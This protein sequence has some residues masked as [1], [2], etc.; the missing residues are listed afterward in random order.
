MTEWIVSSAVLILVVIVLRLIFRGRISLRLQYALWGIVLL[1]LL[2]PVS[3]GSSS[4][5]AA[6]IPGT[7]AKQPVIQPVIQA[8]QQP[9]VDYEEAYHQ[10]VERHEALGTDVSQ[11]PESELE[12]LRQEAQAIVESRSF[13]SILW[14][15]LPTIWIVGAAIM[16]VLLC[17]VNIRFY[18]SLYKHRRPLAVPGSKLRV[19]VADNTDTPCL[20]G[21]VKP[22]VYV[23]EAVSEDAVLL[24]HSIAHETTH[25]CHGDHIWSLLRGVCL[26]V[27]WYNPLVWWAAFLSQADAELACDE[28]TIRRLGEEERAEYGRT[29]IGMTCRKQTNVLSTATTMHTGKRGIKERILL[30]AKKPKTVIIALIAVVLIAAVAVVCT[31]TGAASGDSAPGESGDREAMEGTVQ[32][33]TIFPDGQVTDITIHYQNRTDIPVGKQEMRKILAWARGFSY[34]MPMEEEPAENNGSITLHYAD[35]TSV[36][37][38]IDVQEVN[39]VR[40]QVMHS[41][42]PVNW[43]RLV[44]L[45]EPEPIVPP[46]LPPDVTQPTWP[47][48]PP[49][50]PEQGGDREPEYIPPAE[51]VP[52]TPINVPV[53]Q[54]DVP[55]IGTLYERADP[56]RI[57]IAVQPTGVARSGDHIFYI[58]PEDQ[59]AFF[60]A[61]K[62]AV[63][64]YSSQ[65]RDLSEPAGWAVHYNNTRLYAYTDGTLS[66]FYGTYTDPE[67]TKDLYDL[68]VQAIRAKGIGE[69][70]YPSD[71]VGI[72]SVTMELYGTHT[73]WDGEKLRTL[74]SWLV[75]AE[76]LYGGAGCPFT[77]PLTIQLNNGETKTIMIAGDSCCAFM[78]N[79]VYYQYLHEDNRVFFELFDL[80]QLLHGAVEQGGESIVNMSWRWALDWDLYGDTYG[81]WA[82]TEAMKMVLQW[83][84]EE[85][86]YYRIE[87][88]IDIFW[89]AEDYQTE[90]A[91]MLKYLYETHSLE[92]SK[93]ALQWMSD[94]QSI[95]IFKLLAEQLDMDASTL[96][97]RM[98]V[99][100]E[101]ADSEK[102]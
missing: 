37:A 16:A 39:G 54:I 95:R 6:N 98:E 72:R 59:E 33:T 21:F 19:Y 79:G 2:L 11:L 17:F 51:T 86:D 3:F 31:F 82:V 75:N 48:T 46:T 84:E 26:A 94:E 8:V 91:Q 90:F 57:C 41:E 81:R 61:Y 60:A 53:A 9:A 15:S 18:A 78:S 30:I 27:H 29:L 65:N 49:T 10:V 69:P 34:G 43:Y 47:D 1:R 38:G 67:N 58:I 50:T 24:R 70:V 64:E 14:D 80:M 93:T 66:T 12:V 25:F 56:D 22:A 42:F 7:V 87:R 71:L 102:P 92:F 101:E 44:G 100:L 76:P 40:Y 55:G 4:A 63:S 36:T 62:L 52:T 32:G 96:R 35:G 77:I 83:V 23:T 73:L 28:G 99:I 45:P 89:T 85:P 97:R 13:W 5:S 20:F 88:F 68:C 74:E